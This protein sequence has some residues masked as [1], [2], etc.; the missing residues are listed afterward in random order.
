MSVEQ[1]QRS[2]NSLDREIAD[3]EKKKAVKDKEVAT[4]QGKI[5]SIQKSITKHTSLTSLS[6]K[7]RQIAAYESDRAK[8][9]VIVPTSARKLRI[10]KI[11]GLLS[12]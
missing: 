1:Y 9:R 12:I 5:N 3:L 2:V 8:K 7:Q 4:L 11:K 6:N 10:K